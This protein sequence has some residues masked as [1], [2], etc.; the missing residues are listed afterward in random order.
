[1]P[2]DLEQLQTI[3]SQALAILADVT[4]NPKP[5]YSLDGQT[6]SWGDYLAK[7]RETIDWCERKLAG[8]EPFE[9]HSRGT[10]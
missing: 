1:M 6:V 8:C 9:I 7:L 10:T 2:S 5:S 3:R 4:A